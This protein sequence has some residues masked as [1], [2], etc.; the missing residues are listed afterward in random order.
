MTSEII[1]LYFIIAFVLSVVGAYYDYCHSYSHEDIETYFDKDFSLPAHI[2]MWF[3]WP[4]VLL[5]LFIMVF[6][7]NIYMIAVILLD[8]I[9]G[10]KKK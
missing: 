9:F 3:F 2:C 5:A 6:I 4:I 10:G 7:P 8:K 1:L